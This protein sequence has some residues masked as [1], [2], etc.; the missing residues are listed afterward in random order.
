MLVYKSGQNDFSVCVGKRLG[1]TEI[2]ADFFNS[3]VFY[4]NVAFYHA[5]AFYVGDNVFKTFHNHFSVKK[6]LP[7]CARN[8]KVKSKIEF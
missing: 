2:V 7:L 3:A 5:F 1:Y 4:G 8:V 6:I